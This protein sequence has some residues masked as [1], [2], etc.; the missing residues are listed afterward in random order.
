MGEYVKKKNG[1]A[2]KMMTKMIVVSQGV[3]KWISFSSAGV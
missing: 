3:G 2:L 1:D